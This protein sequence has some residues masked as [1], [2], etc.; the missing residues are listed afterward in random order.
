M[1]PFRRRRPVHSRHESMSEHGD[2]SRNRTDMSAV[3]ARHLTIRS[4]GRIWQPLA[5]SNRGPSLSE[6]DALPTELSGIK[7][8][9]PHD[10]TRTCIHDIRNVALIHLSYVGIGASDGIRTRVAALRGQIPGRWKTEAT[11]VWAQRPEKKWLPPQVSNLPS[12]VNNRQPSPRWLDGNIFARLV[13]P[14]GIEPTTSCLQSRRSP[15]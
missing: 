3:A 13:E 8:I 9:G 2:Q 1:H 15:F 4:S 14:D 7:R 6:S 5:A 12:P 11:A 10:R